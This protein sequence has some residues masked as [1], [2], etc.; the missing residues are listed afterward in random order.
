MEEI[1]S[2]LVVGILVSLITQY[3]KT[4][5]ETKSW[6]TITA[7]LGLSVIVGILYH[8]FADTEV[9]TTIMQILVYAGAFYA[10]IIERFES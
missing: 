2:L 8:F 10:Y 4:K 5:F 9:Y 1:T 7:C 3:L 6:Q